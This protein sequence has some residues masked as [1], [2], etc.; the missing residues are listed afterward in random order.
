V[1]FVGSRRKFAILS[2]RLAEAGVD[3]AAL[4][5]V[6]ASAGLD[7]HAITPEE[8]ALSI[9]ARVVGWRRRGNRDAP[10]P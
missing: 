5:A 8:I 9:L 7:I 3:P 6:A 2:A 10:A 1:A 4:A